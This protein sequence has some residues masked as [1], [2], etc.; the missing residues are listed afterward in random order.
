MTS[1]R[2]WPLLNIAEA[3]FFLQR[4]CMPNQST[5]NSNYAEGEGDK[6]TTHRAIP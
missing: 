1:D 6:R 2:L 3:F 4:F 5:M